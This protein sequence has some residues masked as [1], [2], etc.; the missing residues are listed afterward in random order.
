MKKWL[1]RT[2]RR[3]VRTYNGKSEFW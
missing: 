1:K 3:G 2:V